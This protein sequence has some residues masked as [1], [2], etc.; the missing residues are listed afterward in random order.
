M[1]AQ[2][3]LGQHFGLMYQVAVSNLE[4]ITHELS[5]VQPAPGGNC[6]NWILGHLVQVQ[7][8]V[9][10]L[11][12]EQPVWE[13]EQLARAGSDPITGPAEA[14]DWSTLKGRFLTSRERCLKAIAALTDQSLGEI[15]PHPFGGTCSRAELLNLLAFHQTYH[16]GQLG[17]SRRIAGLEGAIKGPGQAQPQAQ[18]A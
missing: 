13:S 8:G 18:R 3:T 9:M 16:T 5:M 12:G 4:G 1:K 15:V 17:M 10:H 11:L 6:A 2:E 7:N 14:I